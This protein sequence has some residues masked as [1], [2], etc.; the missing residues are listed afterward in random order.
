MLML[1]AIL[2]MFS[3][4]LANMS[5][6]SVMR[7]TIYRF[8]L[9]TKGKR[10]IAATW[11][12]CITIKGT[13]DKPIG[14]WVAHRRAGILFLHERR[15]RWWESIDANGWRQCI[16]AD[17]ESRPSAPH[18][19]TG[20]SRTLRTARAHHNRCTEARRNCIERQRCNGQ[21]IARWPQY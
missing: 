1:T 17:A 6:L 13:K 11:Y 9:V 16:D 8:I 14:H 2:E 10:K 20:N 12:C 19:A 21:R 15:G 4:N 7:N 5:H 18:I 3:F